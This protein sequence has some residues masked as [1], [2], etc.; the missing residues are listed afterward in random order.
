MAIQ[1]TEPVVPD[2]TRVWKNHF[3]LPASYAHVGAKNAWM[4]S[5]DQTSGMPHRDNGQL[6]INKWLSQRNNVAHTLP[7]LSSSWL[8]HK[9]A[10]PS[11]G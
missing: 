1:Q 11:G 5:R 3:Y 4:S 8:H 2:E 9:I 6:L 10:I 7:V